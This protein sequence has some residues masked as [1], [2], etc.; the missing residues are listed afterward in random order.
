[1]KLDHV[2]IWTDKLET[3]KDYYM[4]YFGGI[5]NEKYTNEKKQFNSYFLTF[6]SGTRLEI[7]TIP[8]IR[9]KIT[10][11]S[12][13][14]YMGIT[15]LAFSVD[16]KEEVDEKAKQLLGDGHKIINGPRITGDGYYEFETLDPDF[17]RLEVTTKI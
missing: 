9:D 2:A 7:M 14:Q 13:A 6:E 11:L 10:N 12:A 15:H 17:N 1:M 5:P 4:K 16:T 3:L 8:Y